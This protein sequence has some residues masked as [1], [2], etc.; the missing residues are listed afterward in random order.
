VLDPFVGSGTTL[1][2][3]DQLKRRWLGCEIN[4]EYCSWAVMRLERVPERSIQE[5]VE[6]DRATAQR[7]EAIR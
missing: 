1:V 7:R 2:C 5:W 3:A 4:T 6:F